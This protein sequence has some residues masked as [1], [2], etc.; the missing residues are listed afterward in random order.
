MAPSRLYAQVIDNYSG[1]LP[2]TGRRSRVRQEPQQ[3]EP[4]HTRRIGIPSK[5]ALRLEEHRLLREEQ[6]KELK[7][8]IDA[9]GLGDLFTYDTDGERIT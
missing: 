2:M 4:T 8:E 6:Q 5:Q 1:A 9:C 7:K 3:S